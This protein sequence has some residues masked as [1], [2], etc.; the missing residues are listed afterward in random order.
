MRLPCGTAL[1]RMEATPR[2]SERL[3]SE[4]RIHATLTATL[5]MLERDQQ[6]KLSP[7]IE[8]AIKMIPRHFFAPNNKERAALSGKKI[9]FENVSLELPSLDVH[10]QILEALQLRQ[11][12]AFLELGCGSG[13]LLALARYLVGTE[14]EVCGVDGDR[15]ATKFTRS[16]LMK[17]NEERANFEIHPSVERRPIPEC[18]STTKRFDR[19]VVSITIPKVPFKTRTF[20][21]T[22]NI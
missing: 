21:S 7:S 10:V 11:G 16:A 6:L 18:F 9:T 15:V 4:R 22:I 14:S 8:E 12:H 5:A 2:M 19:I 17:L 13:Y 1:S 20:N 3:L